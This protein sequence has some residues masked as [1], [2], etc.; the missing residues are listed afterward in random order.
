MGE[1]DRWTLLAQALLGRILCTMLRLDEA[2]PLI[3]DTH[4][5]QIKLL[6]EDHEDVWWSEDTLMLLSTATDDYAIKEALLRRR[7]EYLQQQRGPENRSVLDLKSALGST[8]WDHN[9]EL[10]SPAAKSLAEEGSSLM[11]EAYETQLKLYGEADITTVEAASRLGTYYNNTMDYAKAEPLRRKVF[12]A[13]RKIFGAEAPET[14]SMEADLA[15]TMIKLY[16][17]K[18]AL[19]ILERVCQL[20]ARIL[21]DNPENVALA[22]ELVSTGCY[23]ASAKWHLHEHVAALEALRSESRD[24]LQQLPQ[25]NKKA[26]AQAWWKMYDK[27]TECD[28]LLRDGI[29]YED[30]KGWTTVPA[31][32]SNF[33]ELEAFYPLKDPIEPPATSWRA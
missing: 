18:E 2:L 29:L 14:L 24:R 4:E 15:A 5:R 10:A 7:F 17:G 19:A 33:K 28:Q 25:P 12:E 3:Q 30:T 8:I 31:Q 23:L 6:G 20:Q 1:D 26:N 13:Y 27:I 32:P 21:R 16:R 22:L 9:K 11:I